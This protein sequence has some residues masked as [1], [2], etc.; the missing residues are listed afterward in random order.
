MNRRQKITINGRERWGSF[1]STQELVNL[2]Q[3]E[4]VRES[5]PVQ[6]EILVADYLMNWF[7]TYEKPRLDPNTAAGHISKIN[8]HILPIIGEKRINDVTVSDVQKIM[9]TLNSASMGKQVKSIINLCFEAAIADEIY[10]HPNPAQDKRFVMPTAVR[11]RMPLKKDDMSLLIEFLPQLKAEYACLLVILIMTGCRR[12][13]ALAVRW[14]DI[15]W[16]KKTLHLQRVIRFR[17]NRPEI[18]TKMKTKAANRNVPIWD[19]FIP[20]L[21]KPQESGFIINSDGEPL[22]ERQYMNRWNAI[23]KELKKAGLEQRF[24][25]HQL[26]HTYATIAANSGEIAPKVLQGMLGHANFQT[27]MNTYVSMDRDKMVESS[28]NLSAEYKLI[29]SG[30]CSA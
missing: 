16:T 3:N 2:V 24:T 12:G 7:E 26:R 22:S 23:Q 1:S 14:E 29:M 9:S 6:S 15:D 13:E 18:S 5:A 10:T 28:Q 25:T 30:S 27:T 19:C 17:N 20:Y 8:K 4:C 11:K 21:G